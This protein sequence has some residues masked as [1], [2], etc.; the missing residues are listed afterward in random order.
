MTGIAPTATGRAEM[1]ATGSAPDCAAS[2]QLIQQAQERLVAERA[3]ST[4]E[5]LHYLYESAVAGKVFISEVADRILHSEWPWEGRS[6]E[7]SRAP[8]TASEAS[9]AR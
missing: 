7:P 9:G 8:A 6:L 2:L 3:F 5:A 1:T 4:D